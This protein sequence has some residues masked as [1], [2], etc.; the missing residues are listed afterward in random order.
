MTSGGDEIFKK[1]PSWSGNVAHWSL[2]PSEVRGMDPMQRMIL[3]TGY[4]SLF[5]YV[6]LH[7][8]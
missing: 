7:F 3:D 4:E 1:I 2:V 6:F 8:Q 5:C